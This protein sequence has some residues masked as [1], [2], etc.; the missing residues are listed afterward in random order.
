MAVFPLG[1]VLLPGQLLTL[2]VFEPRYRVLMFDLRDV[3]PPELLV[4]MIERGHEVGGGEVRAGVGC[5]ARVLQ[6]EEL[7]DGRHMLVAVGTRRLRVRRWLR[8]DPYPRALVGPFEGDG[9]PPVPEQV[10]S[11]TAR[12]RGLAALA[13]ELGSPAW[14]TELQLAEHP[15][16]L[17]WQLSLLCPLA[18]LDRQRLLATADLAARWDLLGAV[19]DE[20]RE[21]LTA[22]LHL[23]GDPS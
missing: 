22:R 21:V 10:A 19:I 23:G 5:V 1:N 9:P 17:L 16:E 7:P 14:P 18:T 3:Q 4:V 8:D 2:H 12:A 11:V 13:C 15:E 20:Q 6:A